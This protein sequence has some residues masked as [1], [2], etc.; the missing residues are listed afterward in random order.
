MPC[1]RRAAAASSRADTSTPTMLPSAEKPASQ[2][3][4]FIRPP[5]PQPRSTTVAMLQRRTSSDT[6]RLRCRP[7]G[8]AGAKQRGKVQ[9]AGG[10]SV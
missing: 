7:V 3:R 5:S 6:S 1:S 10:W 4:C 9:T 2:S 8:W